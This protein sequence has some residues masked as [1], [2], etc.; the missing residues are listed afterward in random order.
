M[1]IR[2]LS[3][4]LAASPQ[5]QPG[6]VESIKA[7]GFRSILCNRPDQ[8]DDGQPGFAAIA[9]AAARL[10][11]EA[12]FQPVLSGQIGAEDVAEFRRALD[13]LPA[14]VLAYCR[15]GTRCAILWARAQADAGF[16]TPSE[17][18]SATRRAGYEL[19]GL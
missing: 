17:V 3:H 12:R 10:G 1:D 6:D 5:I 2:T 15:T 18:L 4:D 13:G 11:I 8:E 14:P 7:R 19:T 16:M 9:Q